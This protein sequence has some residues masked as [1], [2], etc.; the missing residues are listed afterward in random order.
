[1]FYAKCAHPFINTHTLITEKA[2]SS[3]AASSSLVNSGGSSSNN[4][5]SMDPL[6]TFKAV[7]AGLWGLWS[8][9]TNSA[10]VKDAVSTAKTLT[11]SAAKAVQEKGIVQSAKDG[12]QVGV[13]VCVK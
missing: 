4:T 9:V 1:M 6:S 13:G 3:V 8:S 2:Q 11:D 12:A 7:N 10:V 5:E